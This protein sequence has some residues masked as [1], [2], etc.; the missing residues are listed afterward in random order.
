[1][2][3]Q[4][5]SVL[6]VGTLT[7]PV[8]GAE[9][10]T[11]IAWPRSLLSTIESALAPD[12][13]TLKAV[14]LPARQLLLSGSQAAKLLDLVNQLLSSAAQVLAACVPVTGLSQHNL[15]VLPRWVPALRGLPVHSLSSWSDNCP[16][17]FCPVDRGS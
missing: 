5:L 16:H 14:L 4:A 12:L 15:L 8:H 9:T 10:H 11:H 13:H 17:L 7:D 2:T 6:G 3:S 1:M